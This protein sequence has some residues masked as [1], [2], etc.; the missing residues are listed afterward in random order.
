MKRK[1]AISGRAF[2]TGINGIPR[3]EFEVLKR[4]DLLL[5]GEDLELCLP[6]N[7]NFDYPF[8]NIKIVRLTE[9]K[10]FIKLTPWDIRVLGKYAKKRN[11]LVITF[12][13]SGLKV[14]GIA[15]VHDLIP[16][17][18]AKTFASQYRKS[19]WVMKY[20]LHFIKKNAI[21][22][23]TVSEYSK[24][25]ISDILPQEINVI[26]NGYEH[27]NDIEEDEAIFDKF[28]DIKRNEY[29]FTIGNLAPHKN[30][31]WIFRNAELHPEN[32]YVIAGK[33]IKS[34][35]F[36]LDKDLS[37]NIILVGYISD[38]EMK[39]LMKNAKALVFPTYMEGFGIPPLEA[40]AMGTPA[41][42]SE[43]PC[44]KEIYG[45]AVHYINP[46]DC[47]AD[48][49][50]LLGQPVE[51]ADV[52]LEKYTWQKSAEKWYE[53]IKQLSEME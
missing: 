51:P 20:N 53:I 10:R 50:A 6:Q 18:M 17:K 43:I 5:N 38:G 47:S 36:D 46:D 4:V 23:I 40:L 34:V 15:C 33:I 37:K 19:S 49:N 12:A 13:N 2:I 44:L 14:K 16:L 32:T 25:L 52:V 41:I 1:I 30:I 27:I 28:A 11:A 39:A 22:V 21:K 24:Q 3:Y 48:L 26:P 45:N 31:K 9:R 35:K 29:F 42:V 7:V 8:K